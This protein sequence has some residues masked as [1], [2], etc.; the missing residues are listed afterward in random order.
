[1]F[2]LVN[3]VLLRSFPYGDVSRLV[4]PWTPN[5]RFVGAPLQL[6]PSVPDFLEWRKQAR[7][8]TDLAGFNESHLRVG[9]GTSIRGARVTGNFFATMQVNPALGR[10]IDEQDDQ[11][12]HDND[13]VSQR[14]VPDG[15]E[16]GAH[17]Q[18]E[19]DKEDDQRTHGQCPAPTRWS[20]S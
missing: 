15:E 2:S 10:T 6:G 1:M 18:R 4:Y 20:T 12:G 16:K 8:F 19:G 3:A 13:H 5:P 14:A 9:V 11:P 7:S 17:H